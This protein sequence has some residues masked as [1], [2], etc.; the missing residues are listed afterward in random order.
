MGP[1]FD[2]RGGEWVRLMQW[3]WSQSRHRNFQ[4]PTFAKLGDMFLLVATYALWWVGLRNRLDVNL[5][6]YAV[7]WS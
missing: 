2:K 6:L 5:I 1:E 4:T 3:N 7:G